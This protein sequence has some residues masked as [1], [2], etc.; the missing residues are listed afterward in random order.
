MRG[1]NARARSAPRDSSARTGWARR[2]ALAAG[3]GADG[4]GT[5]CRRAS[6]TVTVLALAVAACQNRSPRPRARRCPRAPRARVVRGRSRRCL[7]SRRGSWP[8]IMG[9]GRRVLELTDRE[10]PSSRD[11]AAPLE[12]R[13]ASAPAL[14]LSGRLGPAYSPRSS[15]WVLRRPRSP[16]S[17]PAARSRSITVRAAPEDDRRRTSCCL[18]STRWRDGSSSAGHD[19]RPS[20]ART[21][22]RRADRP[23]PD[24]TRVC[25]ST[26]RTSGL[27]APTPS[28]AEVEEATC[29]AHVWDWVRVSSRRR[30]RRSSARREPAFSGGATPAGGGRPRAPDGRTRARSRR[31]DR[32]RRPP[33]P[34]T[35]SG[36]PTSSQRPEDR[37]VLLITHRPEG[38]DLVDEVVTLTEGGIAEG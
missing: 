20:T 27:R 1:P 38:L 28:D 11:P 36:W 17:S 25:F 22:V 24:R 10:A 31:A 14:E 2:D 37:S 34:P 19:L 32:A 3:G 6:P 35:C 8:R 18:S 4:L 12:D 23:S 15:R 5:L 16:R 30:G 33:R 13:A 21:D 26:T 29:V 7:L 9:A